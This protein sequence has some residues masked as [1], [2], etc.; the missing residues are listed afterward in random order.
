MGIDPAMLA[1]MD[2]EKAL[3]DGKLT[4]LVETYRELRADDN[5]IALFELM[6]SL[7]DVHDWKLM[8]TLACAVQRLA[9]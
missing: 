3:W 1:Q 5:S 2:R 8:A 9:E 6:T 7:A 4:E